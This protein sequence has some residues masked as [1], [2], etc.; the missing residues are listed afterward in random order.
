MCE[1]YSSTIEGTVKS[2]NLGM[3]MKNRDVPKIRTISNCQS[4]CILHVWSSC[5]LVFSCLSM[6]HVKWSQLWWCVGCHLS[7]S[8]ACWGFWPETLYI[9]R[10][11]HGGQNQKHKKAI[12]TTELMAVRTPHTPNLILGLPS[13]NKLESGWCSI[14]TGYVKR[15]HTLGEGDSDGRAL[16]VKMLVLVN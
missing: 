1:C 5:V 11:Y 7:L 3:V 2:L 14:L 15:K 6:L 12:I 10:A 4:R 8:I 13:T 16:K 9:C